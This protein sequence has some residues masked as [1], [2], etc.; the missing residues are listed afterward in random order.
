MRLLVLAGI[1]AMMIVLHGHAE[2]SCPESL[3]ALSTFTVRDVRIATPLTLRSKAANRLFFGSLGHTLAALESSLAIRPGQPFTRAAYDAAQL[4]ITNVL[5]EANLRTRERVRLTLVIPAVEDCT[6]DSVVVIY[7]VYSTDAFSYLANILEFS[8]TTI[9][10]DLVP[11]GARSARGHVIAPLLGYDASRGLFGG[12][13]A[14]V[15]TNSPVFSK[16]GAAFAGSARGAAADV[17]ATGERDIGA[18]FL[19]HGEWQLNYRYRSE[20]IADIDPNLRSTTVAARFI[21]TTRA[22]TAG[23]IVFRYGSTVEAGRRQSDLGQPSEPYASVK[24]YVGSSF[25]PRTIQGAASYGVEVGKALHASELG[26]VKH[27]VDLRLTQRLLARAHVPIQLESAFN[28]GWIQSTLT[29]IPVAERFYGGNA[30]PEFVG[31]DSWK[32]QD[33]PR[34]RSFPQHAFNRADGGDTFGATRFLSGNFTFAPTVWHYPAVPDELLDDPQL[35]SALAFQLSS[36]KEAFVSDCAVR[37]TEFNDVVSRVGAVTDVLRELTTW[38]M[39]LHSIPLP[40]PV[41]A[42]LADLDAAGDTLQNAVAT[43][44]RH[45]PNAAAFPRAR[46]LTSDDEDLSPLLQ[47]AVASEALAGALEATSLASEAVPVRQ[48]ARAL[49]TASMSLGSVFAPVQ[50]LNTANP[51][52]YQGVVQDLPSLRM[53]L[54]ALSRELMTIT[55]VHAEE[56]ALLFETAG[57]HLTDTFR[58]LSAAEAPNSPA[59]IYDDLESLMTDWGRVAPSSPRSLIESV[60]RLQDALVAANLAAAAR[61]LDAP[62][63][64]LERAFVRIADRLRN[65]RRPALQSCAFGEAAFAVRV[66]DAAFRELNIFQLSPAWVL[67]IARLTSD[68]GTS[69]ARVG[70]GPGL[71]LSIATVDVTVAYVFNLRRRPDERRGAF[72]FSLDVTDLFR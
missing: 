32:I 47:A 53:T 31:A 62:L 4:Q 67:D 54:E 11:P 34:L 18:R 68:T 70:S 10:Q 49:R 58:K 33:G 6:V 1:I 14:T 71:R 24:A 64:E 30:P 61:R 20:P 17:H 15:Q 50:A 56:V 36:T 51:D 19:E 25:G 42:A 45:P 55:A 27:V 2:A 26:F 52:S 60:H 5:G 37:T 3:D 8:P 63:Q 16:L 35:R 40:D 29:R 69:G 41:A 65:I 21:G 12:S 7:R 23:P 39:H 13:R 72:F 66:A 43:V 22:A 48:S 57:A 9:T 46:L 59:E 38:R 44:L 28:A